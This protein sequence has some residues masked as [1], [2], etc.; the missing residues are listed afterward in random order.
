[1]VGS[2][3]VIVDLGNST[4]APIVTGATIVGPVVGNQLTLS[5][6]SAGENDVSI[7]LAAPTEVVSTVAFSA[8]TGSSSTDFVTYTAAQTISGTLSAALA[9]GDI[10]QVSLDNGTSWLTATAAAGATTFT[11]AGI[12]LTSSNTRN[13]NGRRNTL[14]EELR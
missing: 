9:V 14:E 7:I 12:T 8:D 13:S 5:L 1:M 11:L 3:D 4:A 2:G 10:V 6:T